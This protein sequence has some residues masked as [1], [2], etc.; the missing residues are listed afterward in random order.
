MSA[1]PHKG[2]AGWRVP[3]EILAG[4]ESSGTHGMPFMYF[5]K[6][7]LALSIF[8]LAACCAHVRVDDQL[9]K[10]G[11]PYQEFFILVDAP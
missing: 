4:A 10:V 2:G 11:A 5:R 3:P 1:Q 9:P 6:Y 8:F 7:F